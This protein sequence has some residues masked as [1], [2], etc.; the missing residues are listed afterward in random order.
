MRLMKDPPT[1]GELTFLVS[2]H[3][4][5]SSYGRSECCEEIGKRMNLTHI[6]IELVETMLCAHR[7]RLHY[8][9]LTKVFACALKTKT[10]SDQG[11][12]IEPRTKMAETTRRRGL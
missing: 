10:I 3:L 8:M 6:P 11:H 12:G 4:L 5:C 2:K 1:P 9:Y 7:L